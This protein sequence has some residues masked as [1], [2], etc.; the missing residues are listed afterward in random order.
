[1]SVWDRVTFEGGGEGWGLTWIWL[2][3]RSVCLLF[4]PWGAGNGKHMVFP[5]LSPAAHS[6]GEQPFHIFQ[7]NSYKG[8]ISLSR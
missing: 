2:R 7:T 5:T 1:M 6:A 3:I 4:K 8:K